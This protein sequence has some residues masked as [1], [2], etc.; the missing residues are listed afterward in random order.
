MK[1]NFRTVKDL[2]AAK[3]PI[4]SL[5]DKRKKRENEDDHIFFGGSKH[6]QFRDV[7]DYITGIREFDVPF[8]SRVCIDIG[9]RAGKWFSVE[10]EDKMVKNIEVFSG[11]RAMPEMKILAY[12]IETSKDPLKFPD[13]EKDE[14]MMI[15]LMYEG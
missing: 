14:I 2:T 8:H 5:I 7:T 1:I 9:L 15:S 4:K 3:S 11:Q 13:A 10:V 6:Q 12:D